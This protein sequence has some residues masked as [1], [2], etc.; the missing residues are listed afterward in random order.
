MALYILIAVMVVV[1]VLCFSGMIWYAWQEKPVFI[2]RK[3]KVQLFFSGIIAFI[4]DTLGIGSFASNIFLAKFFKTFPDEELP[5]VNNGAQLL[6]GFLEAFF[7]L[8]LI[9]VDITTLVTLVIGTSIGGLIGGLFVSRLNPQSIRLVMVFA[10]SSIAL[11]L[12]CHRFQWL[13]LTGD[14]IALSGFKLALGFFGLMICG[15]LTAAGVG[16]FVM[17]QAILF[18]LNVSP[19]I[20]FPIMTVAGAMQQPLTTGAFLFNRRIPLRK[21]FILTA[22]GCVGVLLTLSVFTHIKVAWLHNLLL[23]LLIVNTYSIGRNY[24]RLQ[25]KRSPDKRDGTFTWVS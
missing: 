13:P 12:L 14:E 23:V 22:G 19:L 16:L 5:A 9:N 11:L 6:P 7:F 4:A 1:N 2:H 18:L 21:T 20:A 8:S 10:F 3:Q 17:V 25:G 15:A 24:I